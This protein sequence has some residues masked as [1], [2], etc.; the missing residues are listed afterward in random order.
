MCGIAG[1]LSPCKPVL[2]SSIQKMTDAIIHRGPD[3]AGF[4]INENK[5]VGLGHRRLSIIDLSNAGHQPM[6]YLNRYTI[7]FNGEI[8]N[9]LEL[10]QQLLSF[11]YKFSSQSD[12]EVILAAYDKYGEECL[13]LFDGM[14][15]FAIWDSQEKNLFLARDRFGE[16][17]LFFAKH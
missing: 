3:G 17:P 8:Y 15:A 11:G 12:T 4:W 6:H 13:S 2:E 7:S 14:F 16:K 9:Y 10:R 1:I 5:D